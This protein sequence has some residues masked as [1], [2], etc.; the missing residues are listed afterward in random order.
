M[1][2]QTWCA[3]VHLICA[4]LYNRWMHAYMHMF[5]KTTQ[6]IQNQ[7]QMHIHTIGEVY[8]QGVIGYIPAHRR[9]DDTAHVREE[10]LRPRRPVH[11]QRLQRD[12]LEQQH[13]TYMEEWSEHGRG[14]AEAWL[15]QQHRTGKQTTRNS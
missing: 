13:H 15:E 4:R 3:F 7:M 6:H 10:S 8:S 12:S 1:Q 2:K 9:L 5:T 11:D 14:R